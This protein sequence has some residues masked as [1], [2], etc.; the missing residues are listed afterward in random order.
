M[1]GHADGLQGEHVRKL[2]LVGDLL[3]GAEADPL[4]LAALIA[5]P[6]QHISH[7]LTVVGLPG[8]DPLRLAAVQ[9]F[10]RSLKGKRNYPFDS[11]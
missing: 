2:L 3:G 9:E 7:S 10:H 5:K 6:R 4:H 11:G 1:E 8:I